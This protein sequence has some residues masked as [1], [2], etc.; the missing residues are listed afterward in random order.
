[1]EELQDWL[2][3]ARYSASLVEGSH[4]PMKLLPLPPAHGNLSNAFVS[5]LDLSATVVLAQPL[6]IYFMSR[7]IDDV[8]PE[9]RWKHDVFV[10]AT[11]ILSGE[12]DSLALLKALVANSKM[13]CSSTRLPQGL[14]DRFVKEAGQVLSSEPSTVGR[15]ASKYAANRENALEAHGTTTDINVSATVADNVEPKAEGSSSVS[16]PESLRSQMLRIVS[17][18]LE[19][20][21]PGYA[22]NKEDALFVRFLKTAGVIGERAVKEWESSAS[23]S[24]MYSHRSMAS[25]LSTSTTGLHDV[26]SDGQIRAGRGMVMKDVQRTQQYL[27][28]EKLA[29]KG[30]AGKRAPIPWLDKYIETVWWSQ[31]PIRRNDMAI[32]RDIGRGAFGIVSGVTCVYTGKMFALKAMDRKLIKGKRAGKLVLQEFSILRVLVEKPSPFVVSLRYSFTDNDSLYF[33]LNLLTGGDLRY[34]LD[35]IK[36]FRPDQARFFTAQIALGIGHLHSLG[37]IYRDLKPENI[38]LDEKGN[39]VITDLGL[40]H[41]L[42]AENPFLKHR[43]GTSGYWAPEVISKTSYTVRSGAGIFWS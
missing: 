26:H 10:Q 30:N 19:F 38:M 27:V 43:A 1:M 37:I 7:F 39:A 24:E 14:V 4:K 11:T 3:D 40:A 18:V 8:C 5:S 6:G 32:F 22:G 28:G 25:V 33:C 42:D 34:H 31:M 36:T 35:E 21:T 2:A 9:E 12:G 13:L 17:P 29:G 41:R 20:V 23:S 16:P 15:G